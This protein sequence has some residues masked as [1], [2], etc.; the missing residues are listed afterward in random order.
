MHV[1]SIRVPVLLYLQVWSVAPKDM[2]VLSL[3]CGT[4]AEDTAVP[5]MGGV[6]PWLGAGL[7][8]KVLMGAQVETLGAN[9]EAMFNGVSK[10][11][12]TSTS[13]LGQGQVRGKMS[14]AGALFSGV[15]LL[16]AGNSCGG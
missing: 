6:G 16:G 15:S 13:Q 1:I 3:G 7:V 4:F 5:K 10:C 2:A 8:N 14:I 12:W 11:G 9:T